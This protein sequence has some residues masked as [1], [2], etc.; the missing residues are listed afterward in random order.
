M[1]APLGVASNN[2][3]ITVFE[4]KGYSHIHESSCAGRFVPRADK[5]IHL[6]NDYDAYRIYLSKILSV[7]I[8]KYV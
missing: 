6:G 8:P 1:D 4:C 2:V 5:D 3:R 7:V